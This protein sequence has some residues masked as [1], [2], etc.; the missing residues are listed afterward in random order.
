MESSDPTAMHEGA[1]RMIVGDK[2]P[3]LGLVEP[4]EAGA[5]HEWFVIPM[6]AVA[7]PSGVKHEGRPCPVCNEWWRPWACSFLPCHGK[8]LFTLDGAIAM[9]RDPRREQ[10]LADELGITTSLV[11]AGR[12]IGQRA[13]EV[14]E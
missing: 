14:F 7:W 8:C 9:W 12:R 1:S 3:W 5:T 4:Y 10:E 2:P 13:C 11:R 6:R